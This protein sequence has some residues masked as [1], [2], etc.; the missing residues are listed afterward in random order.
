LA[1]V[2]EIDTADATVTDAEAEL[3][4]S[5][6]LMAAIV[7]VAGEGTI[8]GA[9]Y[10]PLAEILP[11]VEVPPATPFTDQVTL[12]SE[13]VLVTAAV[14]CIV[15]ANRTEPLVGETVTVATGVTV[16]CA[17]SDF[18]GSATLVTVTVTVDCV[19]T[20]AGAVYRAVVPPV[21]ETV[22]TEEF[23]PVTPFTAHTTRSLLVPR[24]FAVNA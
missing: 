5:A 23:P 18:V 9:V 17:R 16:T 13:F 12:V 19:G 15:P 3:V 8:A 2:T 11:L 22:P 14:N 21:D 1:G 4:G 24:S 7:T 10:N 20:T 6:T